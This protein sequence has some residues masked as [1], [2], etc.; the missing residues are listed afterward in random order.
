MDS[1]ICISTMHS[2]NP[3]KSWIFVL[4][5]GI[6]TGC[7]TT[8]P[9][10]DN[11]VPFPNAC[12]SDPQGINSGLSLNQSMPDRAP[13]LLTIGGQQFCAGY[14]LKTQ[15][16]SGAAGI[17]IFPG[18]EENAIAACVPRDSRYNADAHA[19]ALQPLPSAQCVTSS[20]IE[21]PVELRFSLN[22]KAIWATNLNEPGLCILRSRVDY[23]QFDVTNFDRVDAVL[24]NRV[25]EDIHRQIDL[26]AANEL[27]LR[28]ILSGATGRQLSQ[29]SNPR[30]ADWQEL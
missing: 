30:C 1:Q 14:Q 3:I 12:T 5:A 29:G 13:D 25:R 15:R 6:L 11:N 16:L 21:F 26:S 4:L 10:P 8:S 19:V 28:T 7:G 23:G 22:Y 24:Q 18:G 17:T 20:R 9:A 27:N 2:G